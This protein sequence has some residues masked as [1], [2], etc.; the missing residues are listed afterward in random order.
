MDTVGIMQ[1]LPPWLTFLGTVIVVVFSILCGVAIARS[2]RE[3]SGRDEDSSVNTVAGATLGLLAFILAFTFG[4]TASRYDTR[5]Q[6]LLDEVNAI[7]TTYLRAGFIPQPHCAEVRK[8]IREYVAVRTDLV[9]RPQDIAQA[10]AKSEDLQGRLWLHA[11]AVAD[12]DLKNQAIVALF[13]DSLNQMIDLHTKRVTVG[14]VYRIP[15][16]L[17]IALFGLTVISMIEVGYLFGR[18]D[19]IN[20]LFIFA[21]ALAFSA[22]IL[23]I[24]DLD[25]SGSGKI[26]IIQVNPKP[27]LDL[28]QRLL[29]D[30][31]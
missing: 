4:F 1:M 9:K 31:T 26:G 11:T 2:R 24:A 29:A 19:S 12:A 14:A 6:M 5:R 23:L 25:R 15:A 27:M 20:W 22:V 7:E 10:I 30:K 16:I 28:Q 8:L 18:S 13:M 21:L 17:W 3:R